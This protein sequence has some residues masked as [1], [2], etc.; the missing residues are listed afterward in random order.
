MLSITVDDLLLSYK[1]ETIQQQFYEHLSAAFDVTT[2]NDITKFK[3]LSMTIYQSVDGTS[4]DQTT[5]LTTKILEHWFNH[6][7]IT[8]NI[9]TP[10]PTDSNFELDL[11]TDTPLHAETLRTYE[12]RYHGPF[13]HTIGKL[14]HIQQWT[15]QDINF[16]VTRLASFI[17]KPTKHAFHAL[18]HLMW[19]L[20]THSHEP[21]FYPRLPIGPPQKI[22]YTFSP[23]QSQQYILPSSIVYFTDSAFGNI[24]PDRCSMQSNNSFLNGVITSWTTNIQSFIAADSTDA[25][26]KAIFST[27]K[28]ITSFTHFLTS[29][30]VSSIT[31]QPI[32]LF[33]DNKPAINV[34]NQNKI[35]NRSRHLD[36]PVT[37]SHEKLRQQYYII[38]HIDTK[39]N[40]ADDSTKPLTGPIHERHWSFSRGLRFYPSFDTPHGKY[41]TAPISKPY[42]Y[43]TIASEI[44]I[45]HNVYRR[46]LITATDT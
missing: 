4:I 18:E 21:I 12:M 38:Q 2:P 42:T 29:S 36:I 20:H 10:Y 30:S 39:L 34:V 31:A 3:F 1:D 9:H 26:L 43:T 44:H 13:N 46:T 28:R 41:V 23:T 6:G 19:Y 22:K 40:A 45:Y 33:I 16:A 8:K 37:Y 35:S 5:H 11:T 27:V 15:R 32:T 25:E 17:K 14:L 7:H 24:L